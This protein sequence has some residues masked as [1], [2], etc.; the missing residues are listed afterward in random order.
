MPSACLAAVHSCLPRVFARFRA[1][2]VL[3][4]PPLPPPVG[5]GCAPPTRMNPTRPTLWARATLNRR[6]GAPLPARLNRYARPHR[7]AQNKALAQLAPYFH[8]PAQRVSQTPRKGWATVLPRARPRQALGLLWPASALR[9][10]ALGF[11]SIRNV[12]ALSRTPLPSKGL[13]IKLLNYVKTFGH[14]AKSSY[15][16]IKKI[17][18]NIHNNLKYT[19]L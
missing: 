12:C 6:A 17:E 3:S 16:C 13:K 1:R 8:S 7:S 19:Q 14:V 11:L 4:P 18:R 9:P 2:S 15:R 5:R 10:Q